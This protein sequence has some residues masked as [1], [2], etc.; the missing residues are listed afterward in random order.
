MIMGGQGHNEATSTRQEERCKVVVCCSIV[1]LFQSCGPRLS[2]SSVAAAAAGATHGPL[3][4]NAPLDGEY[5]R[6]N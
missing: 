3:A 4:L 1:F 2:C 6:F 5:I